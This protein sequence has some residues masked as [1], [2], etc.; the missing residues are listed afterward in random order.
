MNAFIAHTTST[1]VRILI[2]PERVSAMTHSGTTVYIFTP[3]NDFAFG[4]PGAF[5]GTEADGLEIMQRILDWRETRFIRGEKIANMLAED[6]LEP[7]SDP[8]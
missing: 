6:P 3:T 1:N 2:D 7:E 5:Y 4:T 8:A